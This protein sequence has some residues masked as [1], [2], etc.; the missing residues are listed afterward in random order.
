MKVCPLLVQSD[1]NPSYTIDRQS[2]T[3]TWLTEC[4]GKK[5]SGYANGFCKRFDTFV[6]EESDNNIEVKE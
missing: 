4:L 6:L 2:Y 3:I 1:T 5:C